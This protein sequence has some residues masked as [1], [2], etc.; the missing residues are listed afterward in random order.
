[1]RKLLGGALVLLGLGA[2]LLWAG[3]YGWGPVVIVNEWE[4]KIPLL[5]GAPWR[6]SV[7][8]PGLTWRVPFLEEIVVLDKRLQFL[9]AEPVEMQ[10]ESERM[11][12]DYYAIW[13]ISDPLLFQRSFSGGVE[14]AS[15][16]IQRRLKSMVGA[17]VG[18]LPLTLLLARAAL[19]NEMGEQV[20]QDLSKKGI[21]IVDVRINRTELPQEARSAAYDQMREQRI[22]ISREHRARGAREAREVLALADKEAKTMVATARAQAEIEKGIGDAN[23]AA[24]YAAAYAQDPDFYRFLRSM[25]AYRA[26]LSQ[27][28]TL[29][30]SPESQFLRYLNPDSEF[31]VEIP[32]GPPQNEEAGAAASTLP[33]M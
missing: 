26:S 17:V 3:H 6:D 20:S 7:S 23:A 24:I 21:E 15:L 9:D 31:F 13:R 27:N 22:A 1:M 33:G 18:R 10:I 32:A 29:V 16:V 30:L 2:G 12:I 19:L 25:A 28:S 4:H 11:E 8:Q 5:L 14:D